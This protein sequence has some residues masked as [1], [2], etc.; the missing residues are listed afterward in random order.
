MKLSKLDWIV[1]LIV[2]APATTM[3]FAGSVFLYWGTWNYL[4]GYGVRGPPMWFFMLWGIFIIFI[5]ILISSYLGK[6]LRSKYLAAVSLLHLI[7]APSLIYV[8]F[9]IVDPHYV[10]LFIPP[11]IL[12]N[13]AL[14]TAF[15]LG[16]FIRRLSS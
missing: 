10:Y 16:Y 6:M 14:D 4:R 2:I 13:I 1:A 15:L 7:I 12:S 3:L 5:G 8:V 11:M 9:S